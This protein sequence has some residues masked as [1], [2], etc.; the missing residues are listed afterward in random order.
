[1]ADGVKLTRFYAAA[2]VC[3]PTRG[4]CLTGRHP[5]RY[6]ILG[7][8]SGH[9][10]EGEVTLQ[11]LLGAR[12]YRTGFFGKWHLGTLTRDLEESNR[13]GARGAKHYAPP[14]DRGFDVTF[15]TEA[16]VPTWDPMLSPVDGTLYGT[17][18]WSGPG[19]LVTDNLAGDDSRVIV[20]RVVPFLTDSVAARQP[21]LAVVW[22]HAP[23]LPVVAGEP[24]RALYPE[25]PAADYKGSI[26]AMDH[27]IGRIRAT[28]EELGVAGDTV[29]WFASDNGP[30]RGYG[31][32]GPLRERKRSLYEGGIRVPAAVTWPRGLRAGTEVDTPIVTSDI[33]PTVME[34]LGDV[35][36][37]ER[38]DGIPALAL[39]RGERTD[40]LAGIGFHS[41]DRRAWIQ[42]DWKLIS[43]G[44]NPWELY[45]ISTDPGET[46]DVIGR[47]SELARRL[48]S[49]WER[50]RV[51]CEVDSAD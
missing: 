48:A 19:E 50:W 40:R 16:K 35:S 5:S 43:R 25:D 33:L 34:I 42:G 9:L 24:Y 32:A 4:S 38:V 18:Y 15:A 11:G 39:L 41:Q 47:H 37:V 51:D 6:G 21:F 20:D 29:V 30:E 1:M 13:G 27:E 31:S 8:N 49:G 17:H 2:P 23:H 3:S 46:T 14:W 26:T 12:G 44:G 7:A 45:D 36:P 10:P 28:L 22:F